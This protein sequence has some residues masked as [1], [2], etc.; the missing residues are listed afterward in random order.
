MAGA[1]LVNWCCVSRQEDPHPGPLPGKE[2]EFESFALFREKVPDRADE[3][4][5]CGTCAKG[6]TIL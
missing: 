6:I 3:G 4:E 5:Q 1:W 2:R